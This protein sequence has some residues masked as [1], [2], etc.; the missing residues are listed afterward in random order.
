VSPFAAGLL[1]QWPFDGSW[2]DASG[3]ARQLTPAGSAGLS[4][5]P[6]KQGIAAM[7][8]TIAGSHAST[9]SEL[10]FGDG[11]TLSAWIHLPSGTNS[12]RTIA[13]N[14]TSGFNTNGFRFFANTF[15][16]S[17]GKL[18]L[19][20]GNGIQAANVASPVGTIAFDRW[21]HV[22][23]TVNRTTGAATL[24]RN[25][26]PVAAGTVRTDFD[27]NA[28]L[29]VAAMSGGTNSLRGTI[30]DLRLHGRIISAAEAW[31]AGIDW[32]GEDS[33]ALGDPEK[34]GI[35]NLLEYAFGGDPLT[36]DPGILPRL[37][38][39]NNRLALTFQRTADPQLLYQV[40]AG[41]DLALPSWPV[42]WSSTGAANTSGQVIVQ[43]IQTI[44]GHPR[45]FLRLRVSH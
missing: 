40:E 21:Q 43:D 35:P 34:D 33:S 1:G 30:D 11:F 2:N 37:S 31:T 7:Q 5:N 15:N 3:N 8:A 29:H 39:S 19:E 28:A 6:V 16:T 42:I 12:V 44:T 20:T 18:I 26:Q 17:D 13:A 23:F 22:A 25:G 32:Q 36:S 4:D 38:I 10:A 45:R 41:D 27:N 9:T 14:S 24:Y